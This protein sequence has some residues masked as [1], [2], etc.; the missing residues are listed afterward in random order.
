[1]IELAAGAVGAVIDPG[2]GSDLVSL[3]LAGAE[4]LFR[5]PW[6]SHADA[7]LAGA[8]GRIPGAVPG[9]LERYRGGSQTVLPTVGDPGDYDQPAAYHGEAASAAWTLA[10]ASADTARLTLDLFSAPISVNRLVTVT[11]AGLTIRDTLCNESDVAVRFDYGHHTAFGS[12]LLSGT[13]R[14]EADG[15]FTPHGGTASPWPEGTDDAGDPFRLDTVAPDDRR[16]VY[17]WLDE[18]PGHRIMLAPED[19]PRVEFSWDGTLMPHLWVWQE[20]SATAEFPWFRRARVVAFEPMSRP[21]DVT[22]RD[23]SVTLPPGGRRRTGV[24]FRLL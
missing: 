22:R 16:A 21:T 11:P 13:L 1:M 6:R 17:G 14:I 5:T 4:V 10:E 7:V 20:L 8:P 2:R 9:W 19:G 12:D 24:A 18:V 15:R 3:T 23:G